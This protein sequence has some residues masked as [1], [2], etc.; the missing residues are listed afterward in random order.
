MKITLRKHIDSSDLDEL[1][2]ET[3]GRPYCFQQQDGCRD[4]SVHHVTV[5][6]TPELRIARDL[7]RETP[8][9]GED[10]LEVGAAVA[11]E[12][13]SRTFPRPSPGAR[14]ACSH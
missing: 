13:L 10:A 7:S 6:A 4:R 5:P 2:Q 1:I 12:H 11:N 9:S 14:T 8:W 3:Y